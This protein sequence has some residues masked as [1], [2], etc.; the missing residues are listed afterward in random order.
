MAR[1]RL[2]KKV[3]LIGS[4]LFVVVV[5]LLILA[6]LRLS[7]KPQKFI[8][9]GDTA[10][11]AAREATD[12]DVKT[13]EYERAER[14][15]H[16]ARS[17]AKTDSLKVKV[18]FKLAEMY[19]ET[20]QWP[21]VLGSWKMIVRLDPENVKARFGQLKYFYMMADSGAQGTWQEV[22]SQASELIEVAEEADL[23]M[24]DAAECDPFEREKRGPGEG[25]LGSYLYLLRGRANS[26]MARI[27]IFPDRDELL[28]RAIDDLKR[29]Q[30]LESGNVDAYWYLAQATLT[31][32]EIDASRGELE[33]RDR[34]GDEAVK[35][36]ERAVEVAGDNPRAHANLLTMKLR[37]ARKSGGL[38]SKEQIEGLE[39]EYL[40]LVEKFPSSAEVFS[41]LAGFYR[42]RP[43][44]LAKAV[45]AAEKAVELDRQN[46]IYVINAASL[47]Y[48]RFSAY[49]ERPELN[50]AIEEAKYA[51][52]LP[53]A[54]DKPGPRQW[55][56]LRNRVLLYEFLARCY[57][58]QVIYPL[59][60][61][62]EAQKHELLAEA[63]QA[64]HE[65]EQLFGV[66]E[67]PQVVKWRGMLELAKGDRN[68]AVRK[69]YS[70]YEQL[71]AAKPSQPP[72]PAD[73]GYAELCYTL[74]KVFE[75]TSETGAVAEFLAHALYSG[76]V[77]NK[78]E[79]IL[80]YAKVLLR[81]RRWP[82]AISNIDAFERNFWTNERSRSLRITG[83]IGANQLD[84]ADKELAKSTPNDAGTV[85]LKLTL[86]RAKIR[87]VQRAFAQKQMREG[88]PVDFERGEPQEEQAIEPEGSV[89]FMTAELKS[90]RAD[91]A[92]LVEKLLVIEPNSVGDTVVIDICNSYVGEGNTYEAKALVNRFLEH[93]PDNTRVLFY[94]QMLEEPE[95]KKISEERR[96]EI[97]EHVMSNIANP[98]QRA[99][100]LGRLHYSYGEFERAAAEFRK[101]IE[102]DE[103]GPG[104]GEKPTE[105]IT[106]SR[107]LAAAYL[108]EIALASKDWETASEVAGV[109]RGE[110]LDNCDGQF[111]AARFA[112]AKGEY[113]DALS[114]VEECLK[115]RP[116]FSSGFLLRSK[117]HAALGNELSS[118]EDVQKAA[119]LNPQDGAIAKALAFVLYRR[120]RELGDNVTFD[121]LIETKRALLRAIG[122][123]PRDLQL[124]SFYAEYIRSTEPSN[125]LAIRQQ[126]QR[127]SPSVENALLLGRQAMTMAVDETNAAKKGVLFD[128]AA[129]ALE[130]AKALDPQNRAVLEVQAEYY[131]LTGQADRAQEMLVE[132]QDPRLLWNHYFRL[133]RFED[134]KRVLE[135]LHKSPE[136][137]SSVVR[138]LLLVAERTADTEAVKKYTEELL[139]LDN[140][141]ANNL[142]QIQTFL[143]TG[144][145][146][147]A[148]HK[149][150]S[151]REKYPDEP[152]ALLLE[153]WLA[154]RRG[155][156]TRAL[157]LTNRN[158]EANQGNAVAWRLR[159]EIN[160]LKGNY[161]Q[162]VDDLKTSKSLF[163]EPVT[164]FALA[165]AYLGA[166]REEDA[167][168]EL[169][170][171]INNPQTQ[172]EGDLIRRGPR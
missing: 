15:Y 89:G 57:L 14:N 1:K 46:V 90:Y 10:V 172:V 167:I 118:M 146:K 76:I 122:L 156:L 100:S 84:D 81:L 43:E 69:L 101:V 50:K 35:T 32:G 29:V 163:S 137:D 102:T 171:M 36:L 6:M 5:G 31:K 42:F 166:G 115:R 123:N 153:G 169:K 142:I 83:L 55:T 97:E 139:L 164:R 70:A 125:A 154:M 72:F 30:D 129:S 157:E 141:I 71:K 45:D 65:I 144:L 161:A 34:A 107:Q 158:L 127:V 147:E 138:G 111:F 37:L 18:L 62:T 13:E 140:S 170:N 60:G 130:E 58:E 4:L 59:E 17:L 20:E 91:M 53:D 52:T 41:A 12:E 67:A 19:M 75:D 21:K 80:D 96:R 85:R 68:S 106:D 9:Y 56:G 145:I 54:Q 3:V 38:L 103:S 11:K 47:H 23:L 133:G 152:G 168:T 24:K 121:Q 8:E 162:A 92:K 39:P 63:E 27:G 82:D 98:V 136:K 119:S 105:G 73:P 25:R 28:A 66:G 114:S 150:Q 49:G 113:R 131:R 117:I 120:N 51:L 149:L 87:Q 112:M 2:N 134:A 88:L 160:L 108:F 7:Q 132:A 110:N 148:E 135:E 78:P 109:A 26:E 48:R 104:A 16:K 22:A 86:V 74:A 128:I 151:F 116:V 93:F 44:N 143:R 64:V 165:K 99:V 95:P 94:K 155:Q 126:L 124:R 159:G 79:A 40:S 61:L 33:E 77:E